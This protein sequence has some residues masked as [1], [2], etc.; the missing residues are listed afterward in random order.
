MNHGRGDR[1][2]KGDRSCCGCREL[3]G[4]NINV[5][6]A[7]FC[8]E[9]SR[10]GDGHVVLTTSVNG[11]KIQITYRG[12]QG[13][14]VCAI[15]SVAGADGGGNELSRRV[16]GDGPIG[17]VDRCE[18]HRVSLIQVD[19]TCSSG[20]DLHVCDLGIEGNRSGGGNGQLVCLENGTTDAVFG[21]VACRLEDDI[22]L[23]TGVDTLDHDIPTG[24]REGDIVGSVIVGR[25]VKAGCCDRATGVD[26]DTAVVRLDICEHNVIGFVDI[27][28]AG[29]AGG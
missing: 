12:G 7:I 21:D 27:D 10:G 8:D 25:R 18:G 29:Q 22:V 13:D 6:C 20:R 26:G 19:R 17:R 2:V 24:G 1:R 14:W 15:V 3:I 23:A 28:V 16:N 11:N 4:G 9:A 5:G